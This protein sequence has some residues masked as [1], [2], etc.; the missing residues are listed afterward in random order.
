MENAKLKSNKVYAWVS[1]IALGLMSAGTTGSYSVIAGSFV[2]PVCEEFGFDYSIFSYY[3]TAT[4]LVG[5]ACLPF[6]GK[7]IPKVVGKVCLPLSS[8]FLF[9][10]GAASLLHRSLD[11]HC[12]WR[13]DWRLFATTGVAMSDVI[14][15]WFK[16]SG[17]PGNRSRLGSEPDLHAH[18]EFRH[19]LCQ[20]GRW[21]EN[22]LSGARRCFRSAHSPSFHSDHPLQASG[23]GHAALW[24]PR[25]DGHQTEETTEDSTRGVS[26]ARAIKSPAFFCIGFLSRSAHLL[27]EPALPDVC[28]RG[29]F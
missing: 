26:Y 5:L 13:P 28:F 12:R 25:R 8:L 22:W 3:F 6:V 11:V 27:H 15:Q 23:Q 29:W 24:L 18:H 1:V 10:A 20:R 4:P 9:A 2:A 14:D 19:H 7:L 16:K 17:V 21:L